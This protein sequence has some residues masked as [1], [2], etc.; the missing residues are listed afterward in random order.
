VFH[1]V[2]VHVCAHTC[3]CTHVCA[4]MCVHTH[5]CTC[6]CIVGTMHVT[7]ILPKP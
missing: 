4:H 7:M 6:V 2:Y 5:V 3:V 1:L